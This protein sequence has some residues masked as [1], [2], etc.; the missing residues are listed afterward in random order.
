MSANFAWDSMLTQL[1]PD[2]EIH[3]HQ[4]NNEYVAHTLTNAPGG[5][6]FS[7]YKDWAAGYFS[8]VPLNPRCEWVNSIL[9]NWDGVI[10]LDFGHW[11]FDDK[12]L[13]EQFV[14]LYSLKWIS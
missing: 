14:T 5:W 13:A 11:L 8:D 6:I 4:L 9:E 1:D 10:R 3:A 12:N 7:V 2:Y